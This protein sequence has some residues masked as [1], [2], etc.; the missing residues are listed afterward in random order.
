MNFHRWESIHAILI[1]SEESM[2]NKYPSESELIVVAKP[3]GR[4]SDT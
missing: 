1:E 3:E 4:S 2:A